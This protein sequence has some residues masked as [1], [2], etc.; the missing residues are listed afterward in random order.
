MVCAPGYPGSTEEAQP[1]M[2]ALARSLAKAAQLAE[3]SLAALYEETEPGCMRRLAQEESSLLLATL[4]FFLVHEQELRLVARLSA[5]PQGGETLERWTLVTG[6]EHPPSLDGYTVESSAGYSKRF[7]RAMAPKLPGRVEI[8]QSSAVLSA[9][10][11]S[12]NGEKLAVLLDGSQAAAMAKLPFA[13][14]L[15]VL[16]TSP[17]MPVALIATLRKRID[18]RRWNTLETAFL[19][20]AEDR[21]AREALDGVRMAGFQPLDDKALAAA[22]T[23]YRRAR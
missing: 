22:R 6:K 7:V 1:A 12:A 20:L 14:S 18:D 8:Q 13:G 11:R 10:K 17:P 16:E 3:G 9:L 15:A 5:M 19:R 21:A 23:A 4:P 2:D